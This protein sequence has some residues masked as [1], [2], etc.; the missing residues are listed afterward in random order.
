MINVVELAGTLTD[1][2]A[3]TDTRSGALMAE[4]TVAVKGIRWDKE[5]GCD[6][7]D[8]AF[9]RIVCWEDVAEVVGALSKGTIVHV[10]GRLTQQEIT[11]PAG[12]IDRKTKIQGLVVSVVRSPSGD[13]F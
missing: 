7:I 6:V 9:L 2:P 11:T 4:M 13:G 10:R 8:T 5:S 12:K 3:M 1:D